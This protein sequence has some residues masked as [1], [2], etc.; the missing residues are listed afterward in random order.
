MYTVMLVVT[1]LTGEVSKTPQITQKSLDACEA[2][3]QYYRIAANRVIWENAEMSHQ[4]KTV[5]IVC[6]KQQSKGEYL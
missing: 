4:V 3:S 2:V 1:L 6:T 5:D